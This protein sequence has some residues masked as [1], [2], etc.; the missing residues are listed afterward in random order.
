MASKPK[1]PAPP[2]DGRPPVTWRVPPATAEDRTE[3]TLALGARIADHVRFM[4][5]A[6]E[7]PG[8]SAEVRGKALAAFYEEL[9]IVERQLERV[10]D[11]LELG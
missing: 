5:A 6:A 10:R 9:K 3:R 7:L 2:A 1:P 8:T 11:E 4:T